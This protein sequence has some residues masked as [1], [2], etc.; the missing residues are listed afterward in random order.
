[1]HCPEIGVA[2]SEIDRG[3]RMTEVSPDH[4]PDLHFRSWN[5]G[6]LGNF[7][8]HF[9][10]RSTTGYNVKSK[11]QNLSVPSGATPRVP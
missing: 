7:P 4:H 5:S 2:D 10:R 9:Q 6:K 1:M 8:G 11:T 3:R